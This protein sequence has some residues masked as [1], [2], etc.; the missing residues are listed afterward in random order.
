MEYENRRIVYCKRENSEQDCYDKKIIDSSF[1]PCGDGSV[2]GD[3]VCSCG[4]EMAGKMS[5]FDIVVY[6]PIFAETWNTGIE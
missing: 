6:E 1:C 5:R 3:L 2:D 4:E